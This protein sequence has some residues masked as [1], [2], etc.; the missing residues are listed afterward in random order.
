MKPQRV[1]VKGSSYESKGKQYTKKYITPA[2]VLPDIDSQIIVS[3]PTLLKAFELLNATFNN[4]LRT[5][6]KAIIKIIQRSLSKDDVALIKEVEK[7]VA[8]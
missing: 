8:E 7:D 5:R 6:D 3:D 2:S 1:K 4:L